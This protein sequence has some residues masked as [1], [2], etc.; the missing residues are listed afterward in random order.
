MANLRGKGAFQGVNLLVVAKEK[1]LVRDENNKDV[2]KGRYLD[3][4]VDQSLK[5]PDK[6]KSGE[7]EADTNPHLVS[8][9]KEHN[10]NQYVSHAVYYAESQ[11]QK[12]LEAAGKKNATLENGDTVL[13]IQADLI[14]NTK[15]QVIVAT[16]KPMEA[17]KNRY[18]GKNVLD[19]QNNVISAAREHRDATKGATKAVESEVAVAKEKEDEVAF[20]A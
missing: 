12:M 9:T 20:E 14:K 10:G 11:Y 18:F 4:Q 16:D 3:V 17:S 6:V 5:N 7:A 1:A 8:F 15:G 13:G 2:I 19:K